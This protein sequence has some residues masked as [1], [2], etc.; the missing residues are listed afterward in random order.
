MDVLT[1]RLSELVLIH[2]R[3]II[4][5]SQ[6]FRRFGFLSLVSERKIDAFF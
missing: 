2:L 4:S 5:L 3:I 1:G 6:L